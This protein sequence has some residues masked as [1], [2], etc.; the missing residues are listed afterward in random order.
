M[1]II[2]GNPDKKY[3]KNSHFLTRI[4]SIFVK[5]RFLKD[6]SYIANENHQ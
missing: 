3:G 5:F 2:K 1:A 4:V 6:I